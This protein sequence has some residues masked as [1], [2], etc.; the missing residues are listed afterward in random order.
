MFRSIYQSDTELQKRINRIPLGRLARPEEV[1]SAAL[2]L[3]GDGSSF[4]N[5]AVL[6]VD[7]GVT[8]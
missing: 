7:G 4:V 3:C 5:G 8:T 2:W 6:S 1:A